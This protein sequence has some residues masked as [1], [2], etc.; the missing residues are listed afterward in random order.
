MH[1]E[2]DGRA[3][4]AARD[5]AFNGDFAAL[6]KR[7]VAA[8][9]FAY[10]PGESVASL[11]AHLGIGV[12]LHVAAA[13][14]PLWGTPFLFLAGTL[15]FYRIGFL[16]HDAAH[17]GVFA[18]AAA[19]RRFAAVCAGVLGEFPSGWRHGHNNHHRAPNVLGRD[20]D[21][22]DRWDP[23]RRYRNPLVAAIALLLFVRLRG[24]YVPR[25]V[26]LVGLRDGYYTYTH[27]RASFARE[28]AVSIGSLGSQ[29]L[30]MILLYG[31]W[32]PVAFLLHVWI[33]M[34]YLNLV[35]AGSHYDMPTY[36][37][38]E[39]ENV[40]FATLQIRT[41]RNYRPGFF[42]GLFAAGVQYH[43]E[44]HLFP[45]MPPHGFA[46]ASAEVRTYCA[47]RGI[48]YVEVPYLEALRRTVRFHVEPNGA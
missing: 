16:M 7:V 38:E 48:P 3:A 15:V 27:H 33:G 11:V 31:A 29:L 20:R 4:P 5:K 13:A 6:R 34:V 8:G 2:A 9:C 45:S 1:D 24:V 28:C 18:D 36:T 44:H 42:T 30:G 14:A 17:G 23:T 26:L 39:A 37:A 32:G 35:F 22:G 41:N 47:E 43:I 46:R 12:G 25:T 21:Q 40:D 19:N 10:R